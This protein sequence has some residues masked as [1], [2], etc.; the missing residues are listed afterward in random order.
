[1]QILDAMN[2]LYFLCSL[3]DTRVSN[4]IENGKEQPCFTSTFPAT[5]YKYLT[6]KPTTIAVKLHQFTATTERWWEISEE[7]ELFKMF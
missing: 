1:M 3:A 4:F 2:F 5:D 7:A 6:W